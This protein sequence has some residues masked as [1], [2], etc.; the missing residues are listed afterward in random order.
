MMLLIGESSGGSFWCFIQNPDY[1]IIISS[2]NFKNEKPYRQ[3]Q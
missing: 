1:S 3:V 2:L